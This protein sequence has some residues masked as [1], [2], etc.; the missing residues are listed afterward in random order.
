MTNG[1]KIKCQNS[2]FLAHP[3]RNHA[4]GLRK[5]ATDT[6]RQMVLLRTGGQSKRWPKGCFPFHM[7]ARA[8]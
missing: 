4:Q 7:I 1:G 8:G 2:L 3:F 5:T 6:I